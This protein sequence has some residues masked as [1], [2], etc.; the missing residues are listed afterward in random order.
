MTGRWLPPEEYIET[1]AR[2]TSYACLYFTDTAGR[3]FQLRSRDEAEVWQWPGG[4]LEHGETP[5]EGARRECLEETG[6]DFRGPRRL[7]G[8][9]FLPRRTRW[10]VNHIGF[11][12]DGGELTDVQLARVR[13]TDEHTEWRVATVEGWR[14]QMRPDGFARLDA[15]ST[16]RATGAVA[17]LEGA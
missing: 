10:P 7:L 14:G 5:W 17:Y 11:I 3:P 4:N 12:F 6:I 2:A 13:L 16:A 9:H 1:I 15:I 8:V